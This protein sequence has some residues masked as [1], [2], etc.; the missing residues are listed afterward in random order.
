M[1]CLVVQFWKKYKKPFILLY[2]LFFM[3]SM[4]FITFM[5]PDIQ[6]GIRIILLFLLYLITTV[7]IYTGYKVT[8]KM[9]LKKQGERQWKTPGIHIRKK[10][11][12]SSIYF[13]WLVWHSG[14]QQS[15]TCAKTKINITGNYVCDE[16]LVYILCLFSNK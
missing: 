7:T 15:P 3:I 9:L 16:W 1:E 4:T 5:L 11:F 13:L 14:Y 2:Y 10:S 8:N 6:I 12:W